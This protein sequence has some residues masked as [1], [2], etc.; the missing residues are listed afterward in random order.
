MPRQRSA[1]PPSAGPT[2]KI[3]LLWPGK[4]NP[5]KPRQDA[6]GHWILVAGDDVRR[7]HPLLDL[8]LYPTNMSRADSLVVAGDRLDALHTISRG[9]R[10]G[11]KLA[12]LDVPRVEVDD[13]T[14]AFR[15]DST[16]V[17][18]T[19]LSVLRSHLAALEPLMRRDGVV[20]I[21]TGDIEEPYARLVADE[22]FARENRIGTVVWQRAY[23]PRNMR[24]MKEFTATH[25]SLNI[26]AVDRAGLPAV[27]LRQAPAG[28]DNPDDD[29]RGPWKAEHKGAH[30]RRE[31][32]DF[33]VNIPPYRWRLS[34]GQLPKGIWRV[35][36]LTGVIW[37]VPEEAGEFPMS[38]EVSDS[39]GDTSTR[40]LVL[41]VG[42]E[43]AFDGTPDVPWLFGSIEAEGK[44]RV[45]T[46]RLPVGVVGHEYSAVLVAA[47]GSPFAG[48]QKRPRSGR[49]WEFA[50]DT[51]V[52][53]Y[54][55]DGVYLGRDGGA[56][57]HP[58]GYLVDVGDEVV[59]NQVSWWPGRI[60][61]K[62]GTE[63]FAG[64]TEDATK[65]L[66]K[67]VE[68]GLVR[69]IV[70]TAKPER[71]LSRVVDLFTVG[72]DIVLEVFGAAAGLSAVALKRGRRFIY[73][74]GA[75]DR[76]H[77]LLEEC[78]WPRLRAVID[79]R[80]RGLEDVSGEIR[81]R[82]DAYVPYDG[83]GSVVRTKLGEP[84]LELNRGEDFPTLRKGL[85]GSDLYQS[86]LTAEGFLPT[87]EIPL[88]G[89]AIDGTSI[90]VVIPAEEFLTP[91]RAG[92]IVS[93]LA[94]TDRR[95]TIYYFRASEDFD[96]ALLAEGTIVRRVPNEV[97]L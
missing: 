28:F 72:G 58:K 3:E 52:K 22:I 6:D 7:V 90:G 49:Y 25:D 17:Y 34:S 68:L 76:E 64:Y 82:A 61:A 13:K 39:N 37:G 75:S 80:D 51:L 50:V 4:E 88:G 73:L 55:R 38:V 48:E 29:P 87:A 23:A 43:G 74:S 56:I 65:H 78:A 18:S 16:Q 10:R 45:T 26:Y 57:P 86:I 63:A 11:V 69:Q 33:A 40:K 71:L 20:V 59:R 53:A 46:K 30:S 85:A 42:E 31:K 1:R 21:H 32:S 27:G 77:E 96:A 83:G 81:M 79:G 70:T 44:L 54:L 8:E 89:V 2:K 66:K 19:W 12:Y 9:C 41:E 92:E 14:S 97:T 62:K 47:G 24:G 94:R 15:G 67:L 60:P 95:L 36:P 91:E 84:L 93:A 35:S 5:V